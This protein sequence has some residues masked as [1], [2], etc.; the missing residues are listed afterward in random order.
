MNKKQNFI[1]AIIFGAVAFIFMT[2]FW[3]FLGN[4]VGPQFGYFAWAWTL[5]RKITTLGFAISAFF[6]GLE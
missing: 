6:G 5:V 2:Y 4:L 3:K 1:K